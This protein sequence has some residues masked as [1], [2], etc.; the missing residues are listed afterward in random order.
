MSGAREGVCAVAVM[1]KA[2]RPGRVKTRLVPPLTQEQATLLNAAFLR[3][4]TANIAQAGASV[5]V[6]PY[7]A[8]A[9][10]GAE[11]GFGGMLAPGTALVLADGEIPMP[12]G[13]DGIG[14]SLLHATTAL[15]DRGHGA[16]CL[17]NSDSPTLPTAFL[18]AAAR[19]LAGAEAARRVVL[20]PAEDGGYYL[21][22]AARAHAAL[23]RDIP[24]STKDVT[25]STLARAAE[26][27]LEVVALPEWYDI[28]DRASLARLARALASASGAASG[29][30]AEE[31]ALPF[32]APATIACLARLDPAR[33]LAD[34]TG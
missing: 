28:D 4:I 5:P 23:F 32:P 14:R 34:G 6:A 22:G 27:G 21:I 26:A 24:W 3:D 31:G 17:V 29:S 8:Y 11:E 25:A 20:G 30:Q 2:P 15:L 18:V 13:I 19:A 9:P 33:L 7:V 10:A 12:A 16:V 1:A